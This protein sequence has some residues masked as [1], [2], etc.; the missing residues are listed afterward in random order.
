MSSDY[1]YLTEEELHSVKILS[2]FH[3]SVGFSDEEQDV[4]SVSLGVR[5]RGWLG[6]HRRGRITDR[7]RVHIALAMMD[8]VGGSDE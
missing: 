7:D 5:V 6:R 2:E 1:G 3:R 4:L 8:T